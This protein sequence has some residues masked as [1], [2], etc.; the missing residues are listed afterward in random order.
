MYHLYNLFLVI[1][2]LSCLF[3]AALWSPAGKGLA[4]LLS[5]VIFNC[6]VVISP[7]GI[8]GLMWY[9]IVYFHDLCRHS[10]FADITVYTLFW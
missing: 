10:Y 7:C 6:V 1:V 3:M 5:F 9:L 8:L 4:S 2:I